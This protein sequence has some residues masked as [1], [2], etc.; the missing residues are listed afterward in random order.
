[1]K[2]EPLDFPEKDGSGRTDI[3]IHN[4]ITRVHHVKALGPEELK[5]KGNMYS[6][7]SSPTRK[8]LH[9]LQ[10]KNHK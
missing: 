10:A 7:T 8:G 5:T 4:S 6:K 3:S 1:M 2:K 9:E